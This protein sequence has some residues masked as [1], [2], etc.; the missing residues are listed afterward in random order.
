VLAQLDHPERVL[1]FDLEPTPV[2]SRELRARLAAGTS[3]A[4]EV[5]PAVAALIEAETL[6]GP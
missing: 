3:V 2:A 4:G 5:P 1:F 6:Y